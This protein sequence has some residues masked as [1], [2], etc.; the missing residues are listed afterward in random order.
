MIS[1]LFIL[2]RFTW[3]LNLHNLMNIS[4]PLTFRIKTFLPVCFFFYQLG[5]CSVSYTADEHSI[6][7]FLS[8]FYIKDFSFLFIFHFHFFF[9]SDNCPRL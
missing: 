9:K 4:N 5:L 3:G 7:H 1:V 2:N 6:Y 8:L